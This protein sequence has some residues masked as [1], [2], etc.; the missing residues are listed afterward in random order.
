MVSGTIHSSREL[1]QLRAL[2][3]D[4]SLL[5]RRR[6]TLRSKISLMKSRMLVYFCRCASEHDMSSFQNI[7]AIGNS[8][9]AMDVLLNQHNTDAPGENVRKSCKQL[10]D[11]HWGKP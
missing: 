4:D 1:A 9:R 7:H 3:F 11:N 5:F 6:W 2:F 10:I 8:Q